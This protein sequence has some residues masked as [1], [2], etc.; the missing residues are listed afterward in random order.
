MNHNKDQNRSA[1]CGLSSQKV[2]IPNKEKMSIILG[3][4]TFN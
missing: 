2:K 1:K 3:N 4:N